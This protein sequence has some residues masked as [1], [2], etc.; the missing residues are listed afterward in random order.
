MNI[1]PYVVYYNLK[2]F[3]LKHPCWPIQ[4]CTQINIKTNSN[5]TQGSNSGVNQIELNQMKM[6]FKDS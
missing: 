4:D 2:Y 1:Y 3:L 6:Q 5:S